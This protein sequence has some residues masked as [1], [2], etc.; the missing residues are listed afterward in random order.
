MYRTAGEQRGQGVAAFRDRL[1]GE[2]LGI[3]PETA[4]PAP[5]R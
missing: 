5:G 2:H 3:S 4:C 1:L